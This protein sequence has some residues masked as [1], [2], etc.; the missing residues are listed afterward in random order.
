M[1]IAEI[2]MALYIVPQ[3]LA[4]A[5][6]DFHRWIQELIM[7]P[8]QLISIDSLS[9]FRIGTKKYYSKRNEQQDRIESI[10]EENNSTG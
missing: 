3:A 6:L 7:P 9:A 4:M 8:F 10:K 2:L 1:L 5:D